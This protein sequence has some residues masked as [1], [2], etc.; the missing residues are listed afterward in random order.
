MTE[1]Q[2]MWLPIA[3]AEFYD[4]PRAFLVNFHDKSYFFDCPFSKSLDDYPDKFVVYQLHQINST[5]LSCN[6]LEGVAHPGKTYLFNKC[7]KCSF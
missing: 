4:I 1:E 3:Y 5:W 6:S 7:R 2:E